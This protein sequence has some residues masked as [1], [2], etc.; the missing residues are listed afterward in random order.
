ME[1][2]GV[3]DFGLSLLL[4]YVVLCGVDSSAHRWDLSNRGI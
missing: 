4:I 3:H 2:Y 1:S